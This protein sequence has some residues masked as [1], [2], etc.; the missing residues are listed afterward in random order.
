MPKTWQTMLKPKRAANKYNK[1]LRRQTPEHKAILI[2]KRTNTRTRTD[3]TNGALAI[4]MGKR[5][6]IRDLQYGIR[7][8]ISET[9]PITTS[10]SSSTAKPK[11]HTD[12]YHYLY[13]TN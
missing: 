8:T 11:G 9:Q 6:C 5:V 2:I 3:K 4:G 12:N 7:G 13:E 1:I 10:D